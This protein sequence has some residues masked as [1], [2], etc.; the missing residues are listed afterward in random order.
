[1]FPI[2]SFLAIGIGMFDLTGICL[3][4]L[5]LWP[6]LQYQTKA[7]AQLKDWLIIPIAS[8]M[9]LINVWFG[10]RNIDSWPLSVYPLFEWRPSETYETIGFKGY[11]RSKPHM[12]SKD[13]LKRKFQAHDVSSWES[14]LIN[15]HK[16]GD[17][18][19]V[20]EQA[21]QLITLF[22]DTVRDQYDSIDVLLIEKDIDPNCDG[23]HCFRVQ[24]K[25]Y[26]KNMLR[27]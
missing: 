11:G 12:M 17:S 19:Q 20:N 1:M 15:A 14:K 23:K 10:I 22:P 24:E 2:A 7:P 4:S 6:S 5:A 25:L 9:V 27:N 18:S 26:R 8:I 21:G 13:D 3:V 16:A